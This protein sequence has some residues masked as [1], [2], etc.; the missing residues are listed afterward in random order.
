MNYSS[1]GLQ[2]TF[3]HELGHFI[4]LANYNSAACD[5][6]DAVM[7]DQ[8]NC[9]SQSVMKAVTINDYLPVANSVYGTKSRKSCGF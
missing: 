4:G 1:D 7:Q 3:A 5:V 2:R 9:S 6:S 8:F